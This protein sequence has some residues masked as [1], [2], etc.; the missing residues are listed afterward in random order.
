MDLECLL[1]RNE[2]QGSRVY[3]WVSRNYTRRGFI[4]HMEN[5]NEVGQREGWLIHT[6]INNNLCD[7][8]QVIYSLILFL[9]LE[10]GDNNVTYIIKL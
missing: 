1:Q 2:T 5:D 8:G 10:I 3:W 4:C 7:L 6:F 9:Y